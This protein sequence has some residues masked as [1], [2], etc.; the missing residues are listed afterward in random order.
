MRQNGV[1]GGSSRPS[2]VVSSIYQCR[3]RAPFLRAPIV[4][5]VLP[6]P[7]GGRRCPGSAATRNH[8]R[9]LYNVRRG[10]A[11]ELGI[12]ADRRDRLIS[13]R[14][15]QEIG[16][17]RDQRG[18][19]HSRLLGLNPHHQQFA[20]PMCR[21]AQH[22][23]KRKE[24]G[25]SNPTH[26]GPWKTRRFGCCSRTR[27]ASCLSL[28][29]AMCAARAKNNSCR[30]GARVWRKRKKRTRKQ[31]VLVLVLVLVR[32]E[33]RVREDAGPA[34][35]CRMPSSASP[36]LMWTRFARSVLCRVHGRFVRMHW[37]VIVIFPAHQSTSP[38]RD[39]WRRKFVTIHC[40]ACK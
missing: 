27:E 8:M 39:V 23:K 33:S 40:T 12:E 5:C 31:V 30:G 17:S 28:E 24:R 15:G 19:Q 10:R 25:V 11:G 26:A 4:F 32:D 29:T 6:L 1:N 16:A 22:R 34:G 35:R 18:L 13:R 7:A 14:D 36:S 3:M 21:P 2:G 20:L 9:G 38:E 37:I